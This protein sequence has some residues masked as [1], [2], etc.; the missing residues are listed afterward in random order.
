MLDKQDGAAAAPVT[1][2]AVEFLTIE[3]SALADG[4]VF[5]AITRHHGRPGRATAAQPAH[6]QRA[7]G[8]RRCRTRPHCRKR[9]YSTSSAPGSMSTSIAN[10]SRA[11][12]SCPDSCSPRSVAPSSGAQPKHQLL[13]TLRPQR[14]SSMS[15]QSELA[16][17]V[18]TKNS[19]G[20]T[21]TAPAKKV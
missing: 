14:R 10:S 2:K 19:R 17:P 16:S 8:D 5:V 18:R 7:R 6:R 21:R 11:R 13:P 15:T 1:H 4:T 12:P 9:A 20:R 3:L